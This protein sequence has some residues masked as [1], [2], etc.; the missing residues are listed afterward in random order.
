MTGDNVLKAFQNSHRASFFKIEIY[1]FLGCYAAMIGRLSPTFR[2]YLSVQYFMVT[3][4][5]M[6]DRPIGCSQKW[7]S[8]YQSTMWNIKEDATPH[9]HTGGRS[10]LCIFLQENS[11]FKRYINSNEHAYLQFLW[12]SYVLWNRATL[13]SVLINSHN[14]ENCISERN[15]YRV[16]TAVLSV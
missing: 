5:T 1:A 2:D 14:A 10:L 6:K 7:V 11:I 15:L 4:W 8:K 3:A 9:S 12:Q 16:E 13:L